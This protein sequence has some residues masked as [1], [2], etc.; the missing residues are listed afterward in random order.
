MVGHIKLASPH[1][2]LRWPDGTICARSEL[3]EYDWMSDD[4]EVIV[5]D[6]P[7]WELLMEKGDA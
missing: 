2:L 4:F 1:D 5:V 7:E 6:S 3:A